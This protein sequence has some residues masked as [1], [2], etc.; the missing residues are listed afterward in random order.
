MHN[1][2]LIRPFFDFEEREKI[3]IIIQI[4]DDA[5]KRF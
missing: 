4:F 5:L 3:G 1:E 2:L